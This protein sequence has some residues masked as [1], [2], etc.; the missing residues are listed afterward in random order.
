MGL[1]GRSDLE[2]LRSV[3]EE[4]ALYEDPIREES[5]V[6]RAE[7]GL[8]TRNPIPGDPRAAPPDAMGSPPQ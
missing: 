4:D 3:L 2:E 6:C 7:G 5:R 1:A 8:V